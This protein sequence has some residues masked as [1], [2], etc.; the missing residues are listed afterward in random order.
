MAQPGN[1]TK[2]ILSLEETLTFLTGVLLVP[3]A[4][5]EE[6]YF[7]LYRKVLSACLNQNPGSLGEDKD[8]IVL[9]YRVKPALYMQLAR[10]N[11]RAANCIKQY[12]EK[13]AEYSYAHSQTAIAD[14]TP[15][16][17]DIMSRY[18]ADTVIISQ[19]PVD[20][21]ISEAAAMQEIEAVARKMNEG[22]IL[23]GIA[24]V[25][26]ANRESAV[27]ARSQGHKRR[28]GATLARLGQRIRTK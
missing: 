21:V 2:A 8:L 26:A 23:Q 24:R 14:Q 22:T 12:C 1:N 27:A 5:T 25:D 11:L 28:I 4:H 13:F 3:S 9:K 19:L 17:T 20:Q 6:G 18:I 7:A 16:F 15:S 10:G